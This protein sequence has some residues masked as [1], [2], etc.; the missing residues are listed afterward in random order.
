MPTPQQNLAAA[1]KELQKLQKDGRNVFSSAE[2][3]RLTRERLVR[4]GFLQPV[5]RGWLISSKPGVTPGDST[6]W[7]ACFWEF[8]ARYCDARFGDKWHLS[9]EQSLLLHG[10][11]SSVPGQVIV[12]SPNG[13]NN[14]LALPFRTSL[15]DLKEPKMR[16]GNALMRR[17]E[18]RLFTAEE[19]LLRV[20]EAFFTRNPIE[21]QVVLSGLRD[22]SS[23]LRLLLDGGHSIIAGRIAGALRRLG[24]EEIANEILKTM[25]S[26]GY[27]VRETDPFAATQPVIGVARTR[28]APLVGRLQAIWQTLRQPVID[29]FPPPPGLPKNKKS[30][31]KRV[32]GIYQADAYHSLSI[33]GYRVTPEL[34]ER[35]ASGA[36]NPD[37]HDAD[38]ESRGAL[39]A[40][41]YWQAFQAVKTAVAGI[42]AGGNAGALAAAAHRD[43]Y[44][45]L[46]QPCV[47]AGLIPAHALAG[48]RNDAVFIRTSRHVP[49]QSDAVRDAIPALFALLEQEPEASVRAVLGHWLFGYI[50]PYFDGNGRIARFL[51]NAMLA[52][53]GY[54][55]TV[56][57]VER[58]AKYFSAL[59][60]ASVDL[61]IRPFATL[62]TKSLREPVPEPA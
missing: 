24:R 61:D 36:W 54:A 51:M 4:Q 17:D 7:Y 29:I 22:A 6:P 46:F 57:R 33:E 15:F 32:E 31:M 1:L 42:I 45:E 13:T 27:T 19:S 18:L 34:I 30:Y 20:P 50:H 38:R 40:R 37:K 60:S 58:R 5:V 16:Q 28:A 44:R 62:I 25:K 39:A 35:V 23:L 3:P 59:E 12:Y 2:F 43:W 52:S 53:G 41:G 55:W 47:A 56:I 49:P 8:C 48:Y 26:A 10:E 11:N 21:A 14:T 9:P